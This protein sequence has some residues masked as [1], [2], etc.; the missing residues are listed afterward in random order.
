GLFLLDQIV[1]LLIVPVRTLVAKRIDGYLRARVR[2]IAGISGLDVLE[3]EHFQDRAARAVDAGRSGWD[4]ERSAGNASVGQL[5]LTFRLL[6]ALI[7]MVLLATF[8]LPIAVGLLALALTLRALVR[9][10]WMV[11]IGKLDAETAG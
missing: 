9:R 6:S 10:R 8:S 4:R 11:T 2:A 3:S 1:W 7:A 5:E